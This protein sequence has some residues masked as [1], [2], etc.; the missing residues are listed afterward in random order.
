[1]DDFINTY[2]ALPHRF[3]A[4]SVQRFRQHEGGIDDEHDAARDREAE[5]GREDFGLIRALLSWPTLA[6]AGAVAAVVVAIVRAA[7]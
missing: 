3:D 1:M 2:P 7:P 4:D 6:A 5:E